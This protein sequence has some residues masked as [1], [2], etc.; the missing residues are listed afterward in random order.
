MFSNF[1]HVLKF[2]TLIISK[3]FSILSELRQE[4]HFV[5]NSHT[6]TTTFSTAI[7]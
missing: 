3:T 5:E 4:L 2:Y 6:N 1:C 7:L